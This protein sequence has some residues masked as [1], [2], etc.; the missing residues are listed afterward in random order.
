MT[1]VSSSTKQFLDSCAKHSTFRF[2]VEWEFFLCSDD[3][4]VGGKQSERFF[5]A[6]FDLFAN[7][8]RLRLTQD[9]FAFQT[10]AGWFEFKYEL[11]PHLFELTTPPVTH[12]EQIAET[13]VRAV[14]LIDQAAA[15]VGLRRS[16]TPV[17]SDDAFAHVELPVEPRA[18]ML[19][20][21]RAPLLHNGLDAHVKR[22]WLN[23]SAGLA[24]TQM[25]ISGLVP[26]SLGAQINALY[27]LEP[28]LRR[29][30]YSEFPDPVKLFRERWAGYFAVL[31]ETPLIGYPAWENWSL[32]GWS[33]SLGQMPCLNP[34]R[35]QDMASYVDNQIIRP[36][37][38][39]T[40]EMR[41]DPAHFD[42]QV[43][44]KQVE[45]RVDLAQIALADP[46]PKVSYM[47]ARSAWMSWLQEDVPLRG[48]QE[49]EALA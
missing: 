37:A 41:A 39:G 14:D 42:P 12:L 20:R 11:R 9:G 13:F 38:I 28:E 29:A 19:R 26:S 17:L 10:E 40:V 15:A 33:E 7:E 49:Q 45:R 5:R 43:V 25:H 2:G 27:A 47:E 35:T 48:Q 31:G 3:Y 1:E 34:S 23:F 4:P 36:R 30:I 46:T 22:R 16:E 44:L 32:S 18:E 6:S 21:Y 8:F 24:S